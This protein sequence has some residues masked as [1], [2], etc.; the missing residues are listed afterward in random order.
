MKSSLV[1]P[2]SPQDLPTLCGDA[3]C[4]NVSLVSSLSLCRVFMSCLRKEEISVSKKVNMTSVDACYCEHEFLQHLEEAVNADGANP[5]GVTSVDLSGNKIDESV[6]TDISWKYISHFTSLTSLDLKANT[7]GP[8]GWSALYQTLSSTCSG[9]LEELDVSENGIF[10]EGLFQVAKLLVEAKH[11]RSLALVTNSLTPRGIPTLC[12]GLRHARSLHSLQLDYNNLG[13]A[14]AK[15]VAEAVVHLPNLRKLGLSDNSIGNLGASAIAEQLIGRNSRRAC[16]IEWVNLSCN[17]IADEG[18]TA[19]GMALCD[20]AGGNL[21]LRNL[22]LSCN[23]KCGNVGKTYLSQS[24][25]RWVALR[26]IELCSLDMSSENVVAFADAIRNASSSLRYIEYYNNPNISAEAEQA[27]TEAMDACDK[28]DV[29][30]R[31]GPPFSSLRRVTLLVG[32]GVGLALT[33]AF[34]ASRVIKRSKS[35]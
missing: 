19:I 8:D 16:P 2:T 33:T 17:S 28:P 18:F 6:C 10:D 30:H 3:L 1:N 9:T 13:D 22:D 23:Q 26:S 14:G 24:A 11:M 34:V 12:D 21:H 27:L 29:M 25:S 32:L 15:M 5:S 31:R 20:N 35:K 7:I 4:A